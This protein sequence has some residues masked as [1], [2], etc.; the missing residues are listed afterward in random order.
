MQ[1][2]G[3]VEGRVEGSAGEQ[4]VV[5]YS[6]GHCLL[7]GVGEGAWGGGWEGEQA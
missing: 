7:V 1:E 6:V 5:G 4:F 3:G 2:Y